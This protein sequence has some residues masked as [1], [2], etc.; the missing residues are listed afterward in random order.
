MAEIIRRL[1]RIERMLSES[2]KERWV[3]ARIITGLTGWDN[4]KMRQAR[5][6]GAIKWKRDRD[7]IWYDLNSLH[8]NLIKNLHPNLIKNLQSPVSGQ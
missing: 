6:G 3:K 2:K 8:P 5:N 7:G 4:N 1:T